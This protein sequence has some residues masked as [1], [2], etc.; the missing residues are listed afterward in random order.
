MGFKY[1]YV[2]EVCGK[3]AVL[4]EEEAFQQGWDYPP[5]MG[6]YG[7]ISARTCPNCTINETVRWALMVDHKQYAELTEKQKETIERILNE[8]GN[9]IP[10][11][12]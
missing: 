4:T 3:T 11:T 5:F 7:V 6:E 8:P 2:C 1:R 10:V 9:M 12:E